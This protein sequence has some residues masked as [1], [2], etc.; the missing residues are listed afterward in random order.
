LTLI[1]LWLVL[2]IGAVRTVPAALR[3]LDEPRRTALLAGALLLVGCFFAGQNIGYRG[4]F[5][6]L[7]M[8]G[9]YA[10]GRDALGGPMA[11]AARSVSFAIPLLMWSE[12][13]R[14]W[15]HLA[16]NRHYPPFAYASVIDQP[17]NLLAW[18]AREAGWWLLIA[19]LAAVILGFLADAAVSATSAGRRVVH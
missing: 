1:T 19:V 15:V 2:G 6:F 18:L 11:T 10:L 12:A 16:I 7:V 5:L 17:C 3:R 9:L 8:P 13:I 14:L 4:V